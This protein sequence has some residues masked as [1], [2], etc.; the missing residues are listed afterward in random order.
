MQFYSQIGQDRYLLDS[1]FRGKRNGVF[2]DIGAYDGQT[3]SN[4]LFSKK[5]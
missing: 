5:P 2:L 3:F 4:S 1:F